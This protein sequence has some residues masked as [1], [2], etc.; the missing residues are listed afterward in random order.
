MMPASLLDPDYQFGAS[1]R[2]RAPTD[3]LGQP[4][5]VQGTLA[6]G[7]QLETLVRASHR[8]IK[9]YQTTS[10]G[11]VSRAARWACWAMTGCQR[12]PGRSMRPDSMPTQCWLAP[13]PQANHHL[14][15]PYAT[16][17]KSIRR[18]MKT[19]RT[20]G[21][22]LKSHRSNEPEQWVTPETG[23]MSLTKGKSWIASRLPIMPVHSGSMT[24][25]C[26]PTPRHPPNT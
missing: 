8:R 16:R 6:A 3:L 12:R 22:W 26:R 14:Q 11:S 2:R 13:Q 7:R 1:P 21:R 18:P 5:Q 19:R 25:A 10:A 24:G 9:T 4:L 15:P 20:S 17:A 23:S